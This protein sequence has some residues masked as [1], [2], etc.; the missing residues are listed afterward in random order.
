MFL[1][2]LRAQQVS[3][4][5]PLDV[6]QHEQVLRRPSSREEAQSLA[7]ELHQMALELEARE[8]G[9]LDTVRAKQRPATPLNIICFMFL[10]IWNITFY[11]SSSTRAS[12]F[13]LDGLHFCRRRG[14][15]QR[16]Q[17]SLICTERCQLALSRFGR[18]KKTQ[19]KKGLCINTPAEI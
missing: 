11:F 7:R 10:I 2:E 12:F 5:T 17:C 4:G 15:I 3:T 6:K 19:K 1:A 13:T 18:R 14:F 8:L 9:R 16:S